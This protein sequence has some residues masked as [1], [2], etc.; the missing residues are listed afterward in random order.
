MKLALRVLFII[1]VL[2]LI[3]ASACICWW[4]LIRPKP[5][6]VTY[7]NTATGYLLPG[8]AP[9]KPVSDVSSQGS[10][11]YSVEDGS[12]TA[13]TIIKEIPSDVP[14]FQRKYTAHLTKG[15]TIVITTRG[16]YYKF[17]GFEVSVSGELDQQGGKYILFDPE[18]VADKILDPELAPLVQHHCNVILAIDRQ[19]RNSKPS[20]FKDESGAVW[21][22]V[23]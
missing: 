8:Y 3:Y 1:R 5:S 10:T 15:R 12:S 18:A 7:S 9:T 16:T 4:W 17:S 23:K 6:Q 11:A 21:Q 2:L 20:T 13:D 22:Q 19:W 14:E